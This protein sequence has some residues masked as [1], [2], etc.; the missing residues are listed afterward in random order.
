[1][2]YVAKLAI[3]AWEST[4]PTSK[5]DS[6]VSFEDAGGDS[7]LLMEFFLTLEKRLGQ[8]LPMDGIDLCMCKAD[9]TN[10]LRAVLAPAPAPTAVPPE[11]AIGREVSLI[12]MLDTSASRRKKHTQQD[13]P[14]RSQRSPP[15]PI[16]PFSGRTR[17]WRVCSPCAR[18]PAGSKPCRIIAHRAIGS[19][20]DHLRVISGDRKSASRSTT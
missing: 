12:V 11:N 3:F 1:M 20:A 19:K 4:L 9:F 5:T 8:T 2:N 7:V 15:A 10:F 6:V 16:C 14:K 17:P 18:R 13:A